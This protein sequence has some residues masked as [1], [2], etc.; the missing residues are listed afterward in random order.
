[1][2]NWLEGVLEHQ[3]RVLWGIG[4]D[5]QRAKSLAELDQDDEDL[6]TDDDISSARGQEETEDV[7]D[8]EQNFDPAEFAKWREDYL[9]ATYPQSEE[10]E[11]STP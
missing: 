9:R 10:D 3:L 2:H 11:S 6:W 4:R 8:D 7:L 1:M 5:N